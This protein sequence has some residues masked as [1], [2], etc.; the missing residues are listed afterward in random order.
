MQ[1][2]ADETEPVG[3]RPRQAR[4]GLLCHLLFPLFAALLLWVPLFGGE[5]LLPARLLRHLEPWKGVTGPPELPWNALLWDGMAQFYPWRLFLARSLAEGAIPLWNPYEFCGTPFLANSQ[6]AP[7][8]PFHWLYALS[9]NSA[10]SLMGWLAFLHLSL[11]GA[12]TCAWVRDLGARPAAAALA[13]LCFMGSGFAVTWLQLPSFLTAGCWL[14]M[15]LL[16]IGRVADRRSWRWSLVGGLALGMMLLGG[17]LQIAFYGLLAAGL[18]LVWELAG[19][20]LA[21][22]VASGRSVEEGEYSAG[23]A[24]R[25]C[26]DVRSRQ[27]ARPGFLVAAGQLALSL[28]FSLA[29]GQVLPALELAQQSHRAAAPTDRGFRDYLQLDMPPEHLVT[30]LVPDYFG[31]PRRGDHHLPIN[32]AELCAYVG[33]VGLALALLGAGLGWRLH[34]RSGFPLLLAVLALHMATGGALNR[35]FYFH[36]PGFGQSGSP[37]RILFL[38]C[39]AGAALA[40]LG[41]EV[42]LR[43]LDRRPAREDKRLLVAALAL[44]ACVALLYIL[45]D[46]RAAPVAAA[47]V[48]RFTEEISGFP[49]RGAVAA[50]REAAIGRTWLLLLCGA[51]LPGVLVAVHAT[52]RTKPH[53]AQASLVILLGGTVVADLLPYGRAF[54]VS[55]PPSLVF[56]PTAATRWLRANAPHERIA[57]VTTEWGMLVPPQNSAF[58]PNA[59]LAY[60]FS[61]SQGY[62]SLFLGRYK[63]AVNAAFG[64]DASPRENGN[65]VVWKRPDAAA[66]RML[67]TRY[68]LSGTVPRRGDFIPAGPPG[69]TGIYEVSTPAPIARTVKGV[70]LA[71]EAVALQSMRGLAQS[72]P[73]GFSET[74]WLPPGT[75]LPEVRDGA[76]G[77]VEWRITG[78]GRR[79]LGLRSAGGG[80]TLVTENYHPGWRASSRAADGEARALPVLKANATFMAVPVPAGASTVDLRYEPESFRV[81][82]FLALL[83]AGCLAGGRMAPRRLVRDSGAGRSQPRR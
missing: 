41:A 76:T 52:G 11:A 38:F 3:G 82:L 37:A 54:L 15:L 4:L 72:E 80:L 21:A 47:G 46:L 77:H 32:Y 31:N 20:A 50:A 13:G 51:A 79:W 17:H 71:E 39:L 66:A 19:G 53:A 62:D 2:A 69:T 56:P 74:A 26:G 35:L 5:V 59:S 60:E 70:R 6:S 29:A 9:P 68:V 58:P 55:A 16:S 1:A 14:P 8:Y 30:L 64:E 43:A 36:V 63:R 33:V 49:A 65:M 44:P 61:E 40:G 34:R 75:P 78:P 83:A 42:V 23:P 10:A 25:I 18:L 48:Q 22:R 7:L 28:G 24:P 45:L 57:G 27:P 12:F 73:T 67:A 81:G